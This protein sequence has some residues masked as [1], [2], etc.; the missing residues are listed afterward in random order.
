VGLILVL[1]VVILGISF[2]GQYFPIYQERYENFTKE[3]NSTISKVSDL[4]GSYINDIT[5]LVRER[6][7]LDA[8]KDLK[9][10]PQAV[11][12]ESE[13]KLAESKS[14]MSKLSSTIESYER[15]SRLLLYLKKASK[16]IDE[17]IKNSF[18]LDIEKIPHSLHILYSNSTDRKEIESLIERFYGVQTLKVVKDPEITSPLKDFSEMLSKVLRWSLSV[19]K[20]LNLDQ[21]QLEYETLGKEI[22]KDSTFYQETTFT[23]AESILA[24]VIKK[25][26]RSLATFQKQLE[27]GRIDFQKK[28]NALRTATVAVERAGSDQR[29]LDEHPTIVSAK[30]FI[31]DIQRL[32]K[33]MQNS[34]LNLD[35]KILILEVD[36]FNFQS[37]KDFQFPVEKFENGRK[38]NGSSFNLELNN[39]LEERVSIA[40]NLQTGIGIWGY[41]KSKI[42]DYEDILTKDFKF[43]D[44]D[45]QKKQNKQRIVLFEQARNLGFLQ[46]ISYALGF[47]FIIFIIS[48][49]LWLCKQVFRI[50][51]FGKALE[52]RSRSEQIIRNLEYHVTKSKES[53]F[54][55]G[56][57][58][59]LSFKF[60]LKEQHTDRA[61]TL[62]GLTVQY[63]EYLKDVQDVLSEYNGTKSRKLIICIDELDKITDPTEVG[64]VLREIKGALY[65]E[66]CFYLLSISEDAV[67]AFEGR[68]VE[69]RDIFES[70]FDEIFVLERLNICTCVEIAVKRCE[71]ADIELDI[72][73][74]PNV[75]EVI[76][77]AAVLASGVPR[78]FLRNM[79]VVLNSAKAIENFNT[80]K[81]WHALFDRKLK[82]TQK[83]IRTSVGLE[84][85]RAD[86]IEEVEKFSHHSEARYNNANIGS[87]LTMVQNRIIRLRNKC[88]R[89]QSRLVTATREDYLTSVRSEVTLLRTWVKF[90]IE[91]EIHLTAFKVSL[92]AMARNE[93]DRR[94][95]YGELLD[96]YAGLSYS[97][98][99]TMRH[100][101]EFKNSLQVLPVP[102]A[103]E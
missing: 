74:T 89:L 15:K 4:H 84:L 71:M 27:Q 20:E 13:K 90:W 63:R 10:K 18:G 59:R 35:S 62:P 25:N 8:I 28:W 78:E 29:E 1:A 19:S 57:L 55:G 6:S 95:T 54:N 97:V 16:E 45:R 47:I 36:V 83:N 50:R 94:E 38:Q 37:W 52:L 9:S 67:R 85:L 93:G 32:S 33:R 75:E 88:D 102:K 58:K 51:K 42:R 82:E 64:N 68:L 99:G 86:L 72:L 101:E 2:V 31:Q 73:N 11:V 103:A 3:F 12:L 46:I 21:K 17:G 56:W 43:T 26:N 39:I 60:G 7:T 96:I 30:E 22:F 40:E 41:S 70:T 79:R 92:S 48:L 66:N 100:L 53:S 44:F 81:C 80:S 5:I 98:E 65:E 34:I 77:I 61:L 23:E 91:F 87:D 76:E 24:K 14:N 49:L 69:Q